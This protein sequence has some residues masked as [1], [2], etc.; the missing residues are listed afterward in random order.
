M[1]F[2]IKKVP[3]LTIRFHFLTRRFSTKVMTFWV[4]NY[5][6][7]CEG[8]HCFFHTIGGIQLSK[9]AEFYVDFQKYWVI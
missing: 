9:D 1:L 5:T 3:F 8:Q 7:Q 4:M 2:P 6:V